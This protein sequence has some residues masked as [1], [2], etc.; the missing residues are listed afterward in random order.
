MVPRWPCEQVQDAPV[1]PQQA[2]K[3]APQQ[4]AHPLL[5]H[6]LQH[7][8]EPP[9]DPGGTH[10]LEFASALPLESRQDDSLAAYHSLLT[11]EAQR[12][13]L[14]ASADGTQYSAKSLLRTPHHLVP[15]V[16]ACKTLQGL[17][18]LDLSLNA[19]SDAALPQLQRLVEAGAQLTS[20]DLSN[21]NFSSQ[22]AASLCS[23]ISHVSSH[24]PQ[25]HGPRQ[26]P[27]S[28][29]PLQAPQSSEPA[30]G[31]TA[32]VESPASASHILDL[33]SEDSVSQDRLLDASAACEGLDSHL[34]SS[35]AASAPSREGVSHAQFDSSL[36]RSGGEASTSDPD[37]PAGSLACE[38]MPIHLHKELFAS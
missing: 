11:E 38:A 18:T 33:A 37:L 31:S 21:N 19:L 1:V 16:E 2:S 23:I 8:T 36:S 6:A 4:A 22:G 17:R 28:T 24:R 32:G 34:D 3:Q 25:S 20:L 12:M 35:S 9:S 14:H 7:I 13:L 26:H 27:V 29:L 10:R 5:H 30:A 15:L